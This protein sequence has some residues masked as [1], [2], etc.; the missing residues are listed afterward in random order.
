MLYQHAASALIRWSLP[1]EDNVVICTPWRHSVSSVFPGLLYLGVGM[2]VIDGEYTCDIEIE[3]SSQA[4]RGEGYGCAFALPSPTDIPKQLCNCAQTHWLKQL[5]SQG[6]SIKV[7]FPVSKRG[8][9]QHS[10]KIYATYWKNSSNKWHFFLKFFHLFWRV[11]KRLVFSWSV[12]YT[13]HTCLIHNRWDYLSWCDTG[14]F[15][16]HLVQRSSFITLR[17]WLMATHG[18]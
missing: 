3:E 10:P 6:L 16:I 18:L 4:A 11:S 7:C 1:D 12:F 14:H 8:K 9:A 2:R 5:K 13:F 15:L 17:Y